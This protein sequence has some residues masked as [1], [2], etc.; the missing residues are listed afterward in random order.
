VQPL[1]G[2]KD[3]DFEM[4]Y[5]SAIVVAIMYSALS[6]LVQR[7]ATRRLAP[8][9]RPSHLGKVTMAWQQVAVCRDRP[10][11]P[12]RLGL[13]SLSIMAVAQVRPLA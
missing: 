6:P 2:R 8:D 12:R 4:T 5:I 11:E 1:V 9:R 7:P 10:R 3:I 13:V